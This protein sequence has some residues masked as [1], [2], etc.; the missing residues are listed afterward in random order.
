MDKKKFYFNDYNYAIIGNFEDDCWLWHQ[1]DTV[2]GSDWWAIRTLSISKGFPRAVLELGE[3]RNAIFRK[4]DGGYTREFWGQTPKKAMGKAHRTCA[5]ADATGHYL[6]HTLYGQALKYNCDFFVEY[7]VLDLLVK[8]EKCCGVIA[9]NLED[10]TLHRF[11]TNNTIIATGGFER[12]Y[13]S[14]T[15]AHTSTGDGNAMVTR[16]GFPLED[17]EFIQFHPTGVYGVGVLITEGARGE[18]GFLINGKGERF[19]EKYAPNA[20][21]LASRDVVSR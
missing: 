14:C 7:F 16:A 5:A 19:M 12:A 9:W 20:K 18:G 2:K 4:K 17:M 11:F 1:Y 10:G 3:Y 15:A 13:F 6:L 8:D 21:D